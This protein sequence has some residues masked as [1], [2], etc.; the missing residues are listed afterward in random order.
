MGVGASRDRTSYASLEHDGNGY[1]TTGVDIRVINLLLEEVQALKVKDQQQ[2]KT[3][4][5]ASK[6]ASKKAWTTADVCQHVV[7][8]A[9]FASDCSFAQLITR[10]VTQADASRGTRSKEVTADND[11][12]RDVA[13][14]D[15]HT[16]TPTSSQ[17]DEPPSHT[18]PAIRSDTDKQRTA[19][20]YADASARIRAKLRR[21]HDTNNTQQQQGQGARS[22]VGRATVFISHAWRFPFEEVASVMQDMAAEDPA[23][24]FWFDLVCNNQVS[25]TALPHDFWSNTFSS[26]IDDIG[27]VAVIFSPWYDPVPLQRSWCLWEINCGMQ[28]AAFEVRVPRAQQAL[29]HEGILTDFSALPTALARIDAEKA[30]ATKQSD[31]TMIAGTIRRGMGFSAFNYAVK[32][33]LRQWYL[34]AAEAALPSH[35]DQQ[36]LAYAHVC[37]QV[38]V[39]QGQFDRI[40]A[41]IANVR[42]ALDIY[43][44]KL[45]PSDTK[46]ISA[47]NN[48]AGLLLAQ[49][50]AREAQAVLD[51]AWD[52]MRT[53]E[54]SSSSSNDENSGDDGSNNNHSNNHSSNSNSSNSNSNNY[55]ESDDS[56]NSG[57]DD[58]CDGKNADAEQ[59]LLLRAALLNNAGKVL[60]SKGDHDAAVDMHKEAMAA[61]K[62]VHGPE[63][64]QVATSL[65]NIGTSLHGARRLEEAAATHREALALRVKLLGGRHVDAAN[66]HER[67]ADVLAELAEDSDATRH[68]NEALSIKEEN[69]GKGHPD[70]ARLQTSLKHMKQKRERSTGT[71]VVAE[72]QPEQPPL[73]VAGRQRHAIP[74][75]M[76]FTSDLRRDVPTQLAMPQQMLYTNVIWKNPT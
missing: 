63:S 53:L 75:Q 28:T 54:S 27:R 58:S 8:P 5:E 72:A 76:L 10:A 21:L 17:S 36:S 41:A 59:V 61:L 51:Q 30:E 7:V 71:A 35:P 66:S 44:A 39:V 38:A 74:Q 13:D 34:D 31:A 26:A 18:T 50:K 67:L 9:T 40:D 55:D 49:H 57:N 2:E 20:S 69:L 68:Y 11:G 43:D 56:N 60:D 73:P 12:D 45:S 65:N 47:L 29:M 24:Y 6:K 4:D 42:R 52:R 15:A 32:E 1:L 33:K 14:E 23:T 25:T 19:A 3:G 22:L 46:V 16:H 70:V 62:R 48:H 64:V 37:L